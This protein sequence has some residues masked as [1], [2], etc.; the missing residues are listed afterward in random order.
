M[1]KLS[2]PEAASSWRRRPRSTR[3]KASPRTCDR[4]TASR[5]HPWV[6]PARRPEAPP[7]PALPSG[8][9]ERPCGLSDRIVF[10][11]AGAQDRSSAS[12]G[13]ATASP[14]A[15]A[16]P[17]RPSARRSS[18][19]A[20]GST[21]TRSVGGGQAA[22]IAAVLGR[23]ADRS[24]AAL[25]PARIPIGAWHGRPAP[26]P[27]PAAGPCPCCAHFLDNEAAG[28]L[29]LMAAAALAL[30]VANSPLAP[31]Y[32][33]ALHAYLG[34]LSVLHWINDGLMAVFFLLVGLEIKR[35]VLDGQLS[36]W[37]RR[38]LPGIA[39]ARRHGGAGADLR[40]LQLERPGDAARLGHPLRH[41]HRLRARA[42]C[43]CSGPRVPTSLKVFL[44]RAG[45][46]RR[47]RRGG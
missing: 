43:R 30:V 39:A 8:A 9:L 16:S 6:R 11:A 26:S 36:T 20:E 37:P 14:R 29:V 45:H 27:W 24:R 28:G 1:N 13:P 34:P 41:R 4:F 33:G 21:P 38:A 2:N 25:T 10:V 35:E 32:F 3:P 12:P 7:L 31:A 47:P 44:D 23:L 19:F 42:C 17:R 15:E 22:A 5:A 18:R 46:H 40:R